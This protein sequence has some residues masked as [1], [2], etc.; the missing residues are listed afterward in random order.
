M[1]IVRRIMVVALAAASLLAVSCTK[2]DQTEPQEPQLEVN[3]HSISGNWELVKWNESALA[4]GTYVYINF[5]RNDR[6]YTMYQNLDSF[7]NV[8]HVITGSYYID[9]DVELGAV[10]R[11]NYD[12]DSGDWAHRYV[13]KSLTASGMVWVAKDDATF[14]QEFKRVDN[15]PVAQVED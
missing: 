7:S 3:P 1:N 14:I 6:T 8:P 12:H 2:N 5:V 15:I 13:V 4:E 10:I 9:T 11:G